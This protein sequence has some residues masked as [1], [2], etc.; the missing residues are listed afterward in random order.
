[1]SLDQVIPT[2]FKRRKTNQ[3][4]TG[5]T[6]VPPSGMCKIVLKIAIRKPFAMR[7]ACVVPGFPTS[8]RHANF[9]GIEAELGRHTDLSKKNQSHQNL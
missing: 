2:M 5:K 7:Q 8:E 1:M 3:L 9:G 4:L 6:A